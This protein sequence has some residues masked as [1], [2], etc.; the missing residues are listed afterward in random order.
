MRTT[1][2]ENCQ[3]YVMAFSHL[4]KL[5]TRSATHSSKVTDAK[6]MVFWQILSKRQ[7][8]KKRKNLKLTW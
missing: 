5:Y 3:P 1:I 6:W 8:L 4:G 7:S 2:A